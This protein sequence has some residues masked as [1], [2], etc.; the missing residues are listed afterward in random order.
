MTLQTFEFCAICVRT[1]IF[2]CN[3]EMMGFDSDCWYKRPLTLRFFFEFSS[4]AVNCGE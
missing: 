1:K 2:T 4:F 3:N